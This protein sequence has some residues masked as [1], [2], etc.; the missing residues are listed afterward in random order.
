MLARHLYELLRHLSIVRLQ[1]VNL[2]LQLALLVLFLLQPLVC[3]KQKPLVLLL[4]RE[5]VL[6]ELGLNGAELALVIGLSGAKL[7]FELHGFAHGGF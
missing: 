6:L 3:L 2:G 7:C 4:L 1:A 5:H